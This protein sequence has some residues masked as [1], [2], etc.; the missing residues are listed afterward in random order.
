[1]FEGALFFPVTPFAP[2][3]SVNIPILAEHVRRGVEAGAGAVF[4]ACGTGEFHA[5]GPREFASVVR[6][7]VEVVGGRAPVFAGAGGVLPIPASTPGR[8]RRPAL[9]ACC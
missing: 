6:T 1:M 4:V 2:D 7:A 3:D 8:P 5:L 9:T